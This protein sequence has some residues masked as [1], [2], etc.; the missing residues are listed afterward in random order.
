MHHRVGR[1]GH[2]AEAAPFPWRERDDGQV[3]AL[4]GFGGMLEHHLHHFGQFRLDA[5]RPR[6]HQRPGAAGEL[7][8]EQEERQSGKMVAVEMRDQD[9]VDR[10]AVDLEPLQRR[11]RGGAAIDQEIDALAADVEAGVEAAAGAERIAAAD[12]SQ[13]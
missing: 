3:E 13:L 4:P 7:R 10:V 1:H 11:Q 2:V 5:L 6:D 9:Q 12:K 8:I